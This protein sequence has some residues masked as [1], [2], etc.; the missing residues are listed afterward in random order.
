MLSDVLIAILL[1][2]HRQY[3]IEN[4]YVEHSHRLGVLTCDFDCP[5]LGNIPEP[6]RGWHWPDTHTW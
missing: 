2:A 3:H 1:E 5:F 6:D 4:P